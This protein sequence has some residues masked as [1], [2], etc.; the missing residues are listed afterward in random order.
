MAL[1]F[2][3]SAWGYIGIGGL[4][5]IGATVSSGVQ[6]A[7]HL[8]EVNEAIK[9]ANNKFNDLDTKWKAVFKKEAEINQETKTSIITTFNDINDS[10][11]KANASHELIKG[12]CKQIQTIGIIFVLFIFILLIMKHND[13]FNLFN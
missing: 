5:I 13:L 8:D 7:K 6:S 12:Q 1:A 3:T 11:S 4:M 9:D 10:I 2:L